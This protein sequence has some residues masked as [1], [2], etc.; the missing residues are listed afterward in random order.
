[1]QEQDRRG[2]VVAALVALLLVV[3]GTLLVTG[4]PA[5]GAGARTGPLD[6]EEEQVSRSECNPCGYSLTG[7]LPE[8]DPCEVF[9]E[10]SSL[11]QDECDE[12]ESAAPSKT[13]KPRKQS[14]PRKP[15]VR[16]DSRA[17]TPVVNG[18]Q[19]SSPV[20]TGSAAGVGPSDGGGTDLL[21]WGLLGAGSVL[22]LSVAGT[23]GARRRGTHQA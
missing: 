11:V 17:R 5:T 1:M 19:T 18:A 16:G 20:P 4:G 9:L 7:E 23:Y 3:A 13:T 2:G 22:L 8:C 14:K 12:T 6:C 21:G 10:R 15:E